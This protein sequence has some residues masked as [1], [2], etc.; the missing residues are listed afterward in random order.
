MRSIGLR[1]P[2]NMDSDGPQI[3]PEIL[4][5]NRYTPGKPIEEV[6]RELGLDKV[7][8]LA[9]NENPLGPSPKAV[10]AVTNAVRQ[11][12]LYPD[13]SAYHLRQALAKH[14]DLPESRLVLGNG[15]VE[16]IR[17]IAEVFVGP[18]DEVVM[19]APSFAIYR[20]DVREAGGVLVEVPLDSDYEYDLGAMAKKI[21]S[22]SKMV[23]LCSP[24][25]PTG[26]IIRKQQ[27]EPFLKEMPKH[28]FVVMD[29]AYGDFAESENYPDATRY[30]KDLPIIVLRTFSKAYGLAGIRVGYGI[31]GKKFADALN[32]VRVLFNVNILAQIAAIAALSDQEHYQKTRSLI[33]KERHF[34]SGRLKELGLRVIPSEAN[35]LAVCMGGDDREAFRS[36]LESGV[37]VR[38]GSDLGMPGWLRVTIGTHDDN[39]F[40]LNALEKILPR[41][42]TS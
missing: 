10:E 31:T 35:F 6:E 16:I 24:N 4:S 17:Q 20:Q 18:G 13:D 15:A 39:L 22:K 12:Q 23:I 14:L 38:P 29:E 36:L 30:L 34:L 40:F 9:S 37:I 1:M 42:K 11:M 33:L 41:C 32:Q 26:T 2:L 7:V 5:L 25:N 19:A 3:R 8:K 28:V 21:T 27:L